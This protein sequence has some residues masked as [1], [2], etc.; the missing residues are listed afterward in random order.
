M[1]LW[2]WQKLEMSGDQY[3]SPALHLRPGAVRRP[4]RVLKKV[5]IREPICRSLPEVENTSQSRKTSV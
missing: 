4:V 3:I 1:V 2:S 5:P